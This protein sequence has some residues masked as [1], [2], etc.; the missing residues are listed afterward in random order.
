MLRGT[1]SAEV[2]GDSQHDQHTPKDVHRW[3]VL[4][5]GG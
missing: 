2:A 1:A 4:A 3:G 5:G